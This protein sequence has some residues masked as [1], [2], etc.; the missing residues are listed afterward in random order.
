[1]LLLAAFIIAPPLASPV[2]AF[3]P[4]ALLLAV[5]RPHGLRHWLWLDAAVI[6]TAVWGLGARGAAQGFMVAV[7]VLAA[8]LFVSLHLWRP[9]P[10]FRR[11]VLATLAGLAAALGLA[12]LMGRGWTQLERSY[13]RSVAEAFEAQALVFE[14]RA[15]DPEVVAQIRELGAGAG[16]LGAYL[17]AVVVLASLAGL[18]LAWRWHQRVAAVPLAGSSAPLR[19]FRFSDQVLWLLVLGL[20]LVLI[21]LPGVAVGGV[22]VARL[23]ANVLVVV[24]ALYLVRGLA[25]YLS[26]ARRAPRHVNIVLAIVAVVFWPFA[27]SGLVMLG[28]ADSWVDFR[29]RLA[30][31]PEDGSH[32]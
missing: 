24:G 1:M 29:R 17:P 9:G 19:A 4:L 10:V 3:A 5:A 14:R 6:I 20:G 22:P 31:Q 32:D 2:F 12:T 16:H 28:V 30:P 7:A 18:A 25:V 15:F 27:A 26:A 21:D 8:G 13:A 23:A 11:A